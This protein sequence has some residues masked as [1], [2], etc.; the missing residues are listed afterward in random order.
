M[1]DCRPP[2]SPDKMTWMFL[3]NPLLFLRTLIKTS[4]P[5]FLL[6]TGVCVLAGAAASG[7][8]SLIN[9]EVLLACAGALLAHI[10]VNMLNEYQDFRSGLDLATQRTPFS[11]GSGGLPSFPAAASWVLTGAI[12]TLVSALLIGL[13]LAWSH[14]ALWPVGIAGALLVVTYT[15]YINRQPWLCL[16]APGAGFGLLMVTGVA[17]VAGIQDP[18]SVICAATVVF[19]L[20]N[21][22]LLANQ[23][24]DIDADALHGRRH[25]LITHGVT[26]GIRAYIMM[27]FAVAA[28]IVSAVMLGIWNQWVLLALLPWALTL[29]TATALNELREDISQSPSAL[30]ANVAAT[31]LTTLA[32]SSGLLLGR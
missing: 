20:V 14:P 16:V 24:P 2:D 26:A 13:F 11:G 21:N 19:L 27:T 8:A 1:S 15:R 31:L 23:F 4:R 29:K 5:P 28:I 22:L 17:L 30:A 18:A 6:L 32:L 9:S 12:V 3:N 10:S 7:S 25:L